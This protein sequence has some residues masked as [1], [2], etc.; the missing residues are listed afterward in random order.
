MSKPDVKRQIS[1]S[2]NFLSTLITS[3]VDDN[4]LATPNDN[5][6]ENY[7]DKIQVSCM[8]YNRL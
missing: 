6:K 8:I 2:R 1:L 5:D 4:L 3:D 7:D